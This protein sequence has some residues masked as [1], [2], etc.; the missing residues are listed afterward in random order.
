MLGLGLRWAVIS[1]ARDPSIV[2]CPA[3]RVGL[4][5]RNWSLVWL[6]VSTCCPNMAGA[7]QVNSKRKHGNLGHNSHD[8][9]AVFSWFA[10]CSNSCPVVK[11]VW[12]TF[13]LKRPNSQLDCQ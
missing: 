7:G 10:F 1:S 4:L 9:A 12:P 3:N 2:T 5:A 8:K 13:G 6:Q 11:L